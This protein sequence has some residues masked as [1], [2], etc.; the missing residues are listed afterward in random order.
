MD[1]ADTTEH[2]RS[3]A[4]V[5]AK[6]FDPTDSKDP[7]W[8]QRWLQRMRTGLTRR[9]RLLERRAIEQARKARNEARAAGRFWH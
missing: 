7:R 1:R 3:L 2:E 8:V 9:Y 4:E 6:L 5:K